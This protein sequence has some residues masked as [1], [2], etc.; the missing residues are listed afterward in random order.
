MLSN[1]AGREPS[2]RSGLTPGEDPARLRRTQPRRPQR[3]EPAH[4]NSHEKPKVL[5]RVAEYAGELAYAQSGAAA[6]KSF[7][8]KTH[9]VAFNSAAPD[10]AQRSLATP[11]HYS[12]GLRSV[13]GSFSTEPSPGVSASCQKA[14]IGLCILDGSRTP[15]VRLGRGG[16]AHETTAPERGPRP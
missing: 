3:L 2:A 1:P 12:R 16:E 15:A 10:A 5:K 6:A 8:Y 13:F 14:H 11:R 9:A 7:I 4:Q